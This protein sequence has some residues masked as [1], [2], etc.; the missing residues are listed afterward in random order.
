M[1]QGLLIKD[2]LSVNIFT[3]VEIIY[4]PVF[5]NPIAFKKEKC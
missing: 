2:K 4:L 3:L 1:K 5:K